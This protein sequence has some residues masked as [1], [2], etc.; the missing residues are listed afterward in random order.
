M[1]YSTAMLIPPCPPTGFF[2]QDCAPKTRKKARSAAT[3]KRCGAKRHR[4][5]KR[6][7]GKIFGFGAK[8]WSSTSAAR[9]AADEKI[10]FKR[11]SF[12]KQ[13]GEKKLKINGAKRR[14]GAKRRP[15]S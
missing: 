14:C 5:A 13:I 6:R 4:G 3:A 12:R 1:F 15:K 7:G 11:I 10:L 9:S 8:R 2:F